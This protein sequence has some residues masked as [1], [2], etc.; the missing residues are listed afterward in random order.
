M[1]TSDREAANLVWQAAKP[2]L[3][4]N[5]KMM[6]GDLTTSRE[7]GSNTKHSLMMLINGKLCPAYDMYGSQRAFATRTGGFLV[8][9]VDRVA[10]SDA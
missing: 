2:P 4:C 5:L 1:G 10:I 8:P 9:A 6:T 7:K 3:R